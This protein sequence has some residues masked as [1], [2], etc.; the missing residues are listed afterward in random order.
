L[1]INQLIL[2]TEKIAYH[3]SISYLCRKGLAAIKMKRYLEQLITDMRESAS[4]VPDEDLSVFF[5]NTEDDEYLPFSEAFQYGPKRKLSEIL[6]IPSMSFPP[7]DQLTDSQTETLAREMERL[8]KAYYFY[9][10]FPIGVPGRLRYRN[11]VRIWDDEYVFLTNGETPLEFCDYDESRCPFPGYCNICSQIK[12]FKDKEAEE[13]ETFTDMKYNALFDPDELDDIEKNEIFEHYNPD[14]SDRFIPSI[15]NYCDRWCERCSFKKRCRYYYND[16]KLFGRQDKELSR[17]EFWNRMQYILE[18]T[19][20]FID[21]E[22]MKR[23]IEMKDTDN[24]Y[25]EQIQ[26]KIRENPLLKAGENYSLRIG[27]WLY[28]HRNYLEEKIGLRVI[29]KIEQELFHCIE[30]IHWDHTMIPAKISRAI[31]GLIDEGMTGDLEDANGSAKV[32]L[33]LVDRSMVAWQNLLTVFHD[34]ET[35]IFEIVDQL[36]NL[37]DYILKIFPDAPNFQ[38]PGFDE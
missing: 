15:Y 26:N 8:L 16:K 34:K 10:E 32:A 6:G 3:K 36:K 7:E 12:K 38:R 13:T 24:A 4:S 18:N 19:C 2:E 23:G 21:K 25:Y 9:P 17:E 5:A 22:I 31:H 28:D 11:L 20:Y 14:L 30:I 1:F 35:E 37:R 29:T 33:V 27:R